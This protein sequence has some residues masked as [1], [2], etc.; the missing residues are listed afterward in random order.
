MKQVD[1]IKYLTKSLLKMVS[2]KKSLDSEQQQ[3]HRE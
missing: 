2:I 3:S 1:R